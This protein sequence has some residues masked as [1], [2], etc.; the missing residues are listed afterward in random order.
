[1]TT[2]IITPCQT[3]S[4]CLVPKR[5]DEI[6]DNPFYAQD[7][8]EEAIKGLDASCAHE[9]HPDDWYEDPGAGYGTPPY[10]R[11]QR[12]KARCFDQCPIRLQCLNAALESGQEYGIWGG[13]TVAE[14]DK[15]RDHRALFL[16]GRINETKEATDGEKEPRDSR[17]AA[18]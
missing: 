7:E 6:L 5:R 17:P 9:T 4:T 18:E 3:G 13:Y 16:A 1:M 15:I 12:A 2:P 11:T 14:R 8:A 10:W